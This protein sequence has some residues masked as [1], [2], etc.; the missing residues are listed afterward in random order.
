MAPDGVECPSQN[1]TC[2]PK[3]NKYVK[4]VNNKD[5]ETYIQIAPPVS[6]HN[7]TRSEIKTYSYLTIHH[8]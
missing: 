6:L 1:P 4:N 8:L 3:T 5:N 2:S 7:G